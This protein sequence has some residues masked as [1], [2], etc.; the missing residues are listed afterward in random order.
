VGPRD[1]L[2]DVERR[3]FLNLPELELRPSPSQSLYQMSYP[4]SSHSNKQI[5]VNFIKMDH[6]Y[7]LKMEEIYFSKTFVPT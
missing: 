7:A 3:K 4:G 2:D 6:Y 1:G 5:E